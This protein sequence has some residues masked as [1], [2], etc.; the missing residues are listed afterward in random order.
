MACFGVLSWCV[1]LPGQTVI[2]HAKSRA[3]DELYNYLLRHGAIPVEKAQRIFTQ[4]VG[5]VAY[6][7]N[8]SCVHRDLKLENILLDKNENV[9][10]VDFGFTREYEGKMSYLQTFC[11]TVCYSAP[12]MLKGE[13]YA[14]EKVDVW[15]LG[16]ILFALLVGELP[17]DDDDDLATKHKILSDEPKYPDTLHPDAKALISQ[18]ISKRP[19]LRPAIADVL[20]NPFLAEHAPQQQAVLKLTQPL[21]FTT[22]LEKLTL[23][24]MRSAGVDIDRVIENVLGQ[25]CDALAGWW[26]LLIEK[27]E[28]KERRRERKRREK[29]LELKTLRRLSAASSRLG[30]E[31]IAAPLKEVEEEAL[32]SPT[33]EASMGRGRQ[34]RRSTPTPQ[35]VLPDLPQLPEGLTLDSPQS[36]KPPPPIEKDPPRHRSISSTRRRPKLPL[37]EKR[38]SRGS[39][40]Q[41]VSTNPDLLAPPNAISKISKKRPLH[42]QH[43]QFLSQLTSLKHWF[44]DSA[45]RAKSPA[46]SRSDMSTLKSSPQERLKT[47][48]IETRSESHGTPT[49][50]AGPGATPTR[51]LSGASFSSQPRPQI[52][53]SRNRSS[54]SPAPVT[55]L[56][57]YRHSSGAGLRGRKSTSSSVSSIRSVHHVPSHSKASSTSSTSNSVHSSTLFSRTSRSPHTSVKVLPSTPTISAFPSNVRLVRGPAN[58]YNESANFSSPAAGLVFAKRKKTPFR[59]PMLSFGTNGNAGSP[60]GKPRD[61]STGRGGS[62]S[63]SVAGRRSGEIIEEED[64]GEVEEVDGF[65]PVP[66]EAEETIWEG[67]KESEPKRFGDESEPDGWIRRRRG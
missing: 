8:M 13:K 35:L 48:T 29:E 41:N 56:G 30:S 27:E 12:E 1:N 42:K 57:S 54:L 52:P 15:S 25:R 59:G 7:H 11:G 39:T 45:K 43:N 64:E 58:N 62:R 44:K 5:A 40:L 19:L 49:R 53:T 23:E 32:S 65:S 9:K 24:R 38:R 67:A 31:R 22:D 20:T 55:P 37:Q 4:L 34:Y 18:M 14:A 61:S 33:P 21:P 10:L 28:R 3:G 47:P 60:S 26:A 2:G 51:Q 17:F 63:T 46:A 16:I 6:V 36:P 66:P 50:L